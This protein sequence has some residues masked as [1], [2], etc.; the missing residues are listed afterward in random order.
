MSVAGCLPGNPETFFGPNGRTGH[1]V[2]CLDDEKNCEPKAKEYCP[3]GY[4]IL[5]TK[6]H[7]VAIWQGVDV[8]NR[9]RFTL[10]IECK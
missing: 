10:V 6:S 7:V 4:Q 5:K 9:I 2:E 3:S 8:V 1:T